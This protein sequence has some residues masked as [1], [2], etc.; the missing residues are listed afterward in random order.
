MRLPEANGS[1]LMKSSSNCDQVELLI[2]GDSVAA[3]V[4]IE[5]IS[6]ALAGQ[7]VKE[8]KTMGRATSYQVIARSGDKISDVI[9]HIETSETLP[10]K[11]IVISVGVNDAKGFTSSKKWII[12]LSKL[13]ALLDSRC[14]NAKVVLLATPP[15]EQFPLL[16]WPLS[17]V[18]GYRSSRLNTV[19]A[20][21]IKNHEN[22]AFLPLEI[23]AEKVHFAE[24]GF[25]PSA[26]SCNI[27]AKN[28]VPF[29]E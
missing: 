22:G 2:T 14:P 9:K 15:L 29:L 23:Q 27:L 5:Q 11:N 17:S 20:S 13:L 12:Q 21:I 25:H 28:I 24:D 26:L 18:M 8:L 1:R 6:E 16:P 4:G 19:S 3:G 7:V 10:A